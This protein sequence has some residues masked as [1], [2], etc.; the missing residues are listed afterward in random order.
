MWGLLMGEFSLSKILDWLFLNIDGVKLNNSFGVV[1][2]L[3]FIGIDVLRLYFVIYRF[4]R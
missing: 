2:K 1:D 3:I 4:C